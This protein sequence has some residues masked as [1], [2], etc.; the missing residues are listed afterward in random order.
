M[1]VRVERAVLPAAAG[2]DSLRSTRAAVSKSLF[3]QYLTTPAGSGSFS[4]VTIATPFV[5]RGADFQ[6]F[7]VRR[8]RNLLSA[9]RLTE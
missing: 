5:I 9:A 7:F 3:F 1:N 6:H 8:A 2:Q 4:P